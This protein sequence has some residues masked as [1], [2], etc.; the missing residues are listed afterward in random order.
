M[1]HLI[2]YKLQFLSE[3]NQHYRI[4]IVTSRMNCWVN[5]GIVLPQTYHAI[6]TRIKIIRA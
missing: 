6:E 4:D 3:T 1:E 5:I 2:S